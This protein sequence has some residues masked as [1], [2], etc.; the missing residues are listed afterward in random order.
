M[1]AASVRYPLE[2]VHVN[3]HV[4][5]ISQPK[6]TL[7]GKDRKRQKDNVGSASMQPNMERT[8]HGWDDEELNQMEM[9]LEGI[10]NDHGM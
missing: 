9:E 10:W 1:N 7:E 2:D 4:S 6:E 3:E 8:V 5:T